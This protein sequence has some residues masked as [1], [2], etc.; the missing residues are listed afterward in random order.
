M[1]LKAPV[2]K[3]LG[4]TRQ[5]GRRPDS[6]KGAEARMTTSWPRRV[7]TPLL[8]Q[9]DEGAVR[10]ARSMPLETI[11]PMGDGSVIS[12]P[13]AASCSSRPA[14]AISVTISPY[15]TPAWDGSSPT[16]MS[17]AGM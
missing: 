13:A 5:G 6:G 12:L 11:A 8:E 17:H 15:S 14:P 16:A 3:L 7:G 2:S 9:K 1:G 10:Q 4:A